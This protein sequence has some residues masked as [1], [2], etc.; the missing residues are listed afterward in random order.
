[1]RRATFL[2]PSRV[3]AAADALVPAPFGSAI[4]QVPAR[5][6]RYRHSQCQNE[7]ATVA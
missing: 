4:E 2:R 5:T 1:M 6:V 3:D 7:V